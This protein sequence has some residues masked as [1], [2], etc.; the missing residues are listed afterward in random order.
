MK[1]LA[2]ALTLAAVTAAATA[3]GTSGTTLLADAIVGYA[4]SSTPAPDATVDLDGSRPPDGGSDPDSGLPESCSG[5]DEPTCLQTAGCKALY[6]DGCD[7]HVFVACA[8]ADSGPPVCPNVCFACP[9][10]LD[11]VGCKARS[12][13]CHPVYIDPG[14]CDCATP[15]CCIGYSHCSTG[16]HGVCSLPGGQTCT[17]TA[18]S[19]GGDFVPAYDTTGSGVCWDGCVHQAQCIYN[20]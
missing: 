3:C 5:I 11:E 14:T 8:R 4:D 1:R 12:D 10:D 18:P 6:C 17:T 15:G 19:C 16:Q 7:Q 2:R 20:R 13:A 9:R